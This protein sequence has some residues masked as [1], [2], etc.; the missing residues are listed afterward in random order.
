MEREPVPA[1]D[2][3]DPP[4]DTP[5]P[6]A[7]AYYSLIDALEALEHQHPTCRQNRKETAAA[8]LDPDDCRRVIVVTRSVNCLR[9]EM[10]LR[11]CLLVDVGR[12]PEELPH[13]LSVEGLGWGTGS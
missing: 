7:R 5:R 3:A 10:N 1:P 8:F 4:P 9:L 2:P 12:P 11:G 13:G 6:P